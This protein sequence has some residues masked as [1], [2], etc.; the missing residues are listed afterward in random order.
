M[1]APKTPRPA[2][3]VAREMV[4]E[5]RHLQSR[6]WITTVCGYE[7]GMAPSTADQIRADIASAI[8][9]AREEGAAAERPR[10]LAGCIRDTLRRLMPEPHLVPD[11][12]RWECVAINP[13]MRCLRIGLDW[14][15]SDGERR[16]EKAIEYM[17]ETIVRDAHNQEQP[18]DPAGRIR[19]LV[20]EYAGRLADA[21]CA[22]E[23]TASALQEVVRLLTHALGLARTG[24]DV[25]ECVDNLRQIA[26]VST[27]Q[28]HIYAQAADELEA[29]VRESGER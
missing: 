24:G 17:V 14:T 5:P 7:L 21:V 19:A 23:L 2:D 8:T 22:T 29:I 25:A 18:R 11:G 26:A 3:E 6:G 16:R 10:D 15:R 9:R 13:E 4:G 28:G 1:T 27:K 12:T 20:Q